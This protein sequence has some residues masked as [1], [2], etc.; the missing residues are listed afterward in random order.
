MIVGELLENPRHEA[1]AQALA[2]GHSAD[3][4]YVLAGYSRNRGNAAR[5]KADERV[6][7]RVTM[8]QQDAAATNGITR[9]RLIGMC[10]EVFEQAAAAGNAHS[11]QIAAIRE[12]GVLS[13]LRVEK[14]VAN[15][16]PPELT[17]E[18]HDAM[19]AA[20]IL[21]YMD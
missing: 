11:A 16:K 19:V 15:E 5:L 10:L 6:R 14:Q 1:F 2:S 20:A 7:G 3:E 18:Q 8:L 12:L 4:A 21:S 17:K 13:G 9:E